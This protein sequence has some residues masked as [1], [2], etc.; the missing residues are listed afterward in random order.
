MDQIKQAWR[1]SKIYP[2]NKDGSLK[3]DSTHEKFTGE[4]AKKTVTSRLAKHII[5]ASTDSDLLIQSVRRSDDDAAEADVQA[6]I[7]ASANQDYI[8]I[9][10][11]PSKTDHGGE[12]DGNGEGDDPP[13]TEE[14]MAEIHER[15]MAEAAVAGVSF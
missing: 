11:G 13:L 3:V 12:G 15:E 7:D 2:V 10:P 8:D 9:E 1:Q 5:G 6:E 14:E 4:M